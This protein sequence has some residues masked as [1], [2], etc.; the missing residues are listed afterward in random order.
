MCLG[1]SRISGLRNDINKRAFYKE[2]KNNKRCVHFLDK[3]NIKAK[4]LF[5]TYII[6]WEN[7]LKSDE[8]SIFYKTIK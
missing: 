5:W 8:S 6:S 3:Q 4:S 7:L 2:R 1:M